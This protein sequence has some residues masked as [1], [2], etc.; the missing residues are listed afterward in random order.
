MVAVVFSKFEQNG[1][2]GGEG[3]DGREQYL[4][5]CCFAIILLTH[6]KRLDKEERNDER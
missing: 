3:K 5:I 6:I 2:K 1:E 4:S